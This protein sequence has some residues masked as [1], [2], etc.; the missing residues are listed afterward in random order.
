MMNTTRIKPLGAN[1]TELHQA[2]GSIVLF[3][4]QTP[5]AVQLAQGGFVH[6]STRYSVTT[7][8]HITQWLK[9]VRA[10]EVDQSEIETLL[11]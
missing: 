10:R 11:D 1:K 8:K 9:G 5:V 6:T 4:Y 7:S 2:D 3:S